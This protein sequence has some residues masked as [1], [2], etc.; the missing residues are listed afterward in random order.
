VID[1]ANDAAGEAGTVV[2]LDGGGVEED[3]APTGGGELPS[4]GWVSVGIELRRL[5][6]GCGLE[7]LP[8]GMAREGVF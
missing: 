8:C 2:G 7:G 3:E 5:E 4:V 6:H 1:E